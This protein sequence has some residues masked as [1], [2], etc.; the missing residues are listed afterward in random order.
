MKNKRLTL[1]VAAM[2]LILMGAMVHA[3][4]VTPQRTQKAIDRFVDDPLMRHGSLGVMVV[5]RQAAW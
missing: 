1:L 5:D 2:W 3:R 4:E